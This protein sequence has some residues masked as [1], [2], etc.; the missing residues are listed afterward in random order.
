MKVYLTNKELYKEIVISK[1]Q[2]KR[3][4]QLD[5]MIISLAKN[6]IKKKIYTNPQDREDILSTM[7]YKMMR[8]YA[9][10]N[11]ERFDNAFAYMSEIAKRGLAEGFNQLHP[12]DRYTGEYWNIRTMSNLF[13]EGDWNI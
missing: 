5:R 9:G 6:M 13:K 2:G 12:K 4:P 1:N 11:E 8:Y 10:F 3:T 7:I